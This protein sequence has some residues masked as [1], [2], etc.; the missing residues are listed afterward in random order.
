MEREVGKDREISHIPK[1]MG[2]RTVPKEKER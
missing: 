1:Q 2:S